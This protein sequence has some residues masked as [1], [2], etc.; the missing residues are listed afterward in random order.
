MPIKNLSLELKAP[1]ISRHSFLRNSLDTLTSSCVP[2]LQTG[3]W[4]VED[5]VLS[6]EID[7]KIDQVYGNGHHNRYTFF[8]NKQLIF[9]PPQKN[10]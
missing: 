9:D 3:T 8:L 5:A 2:K 7:V 6:C 4:K 1:E 10:C